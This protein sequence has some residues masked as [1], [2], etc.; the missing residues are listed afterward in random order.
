[1][2]KYYTINMVSCRK[3]KMVI[4]MLSLR[5]VLGVLQKKGQAYSQERSGWS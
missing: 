5:N 2:N 1:V 4:V 3:R